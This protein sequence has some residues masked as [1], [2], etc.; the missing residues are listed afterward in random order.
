MN[1]EHVTLD[2]F[3]GVKREMIGVVE[4]LM[5]IDVISR[6]TFALKAVPLV[7]TVSSSW[8]HMNPF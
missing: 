5:T 4:G 3:I 2:R 1:L 8:F 6:Q 7:S